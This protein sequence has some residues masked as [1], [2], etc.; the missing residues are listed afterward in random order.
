VSATPLDK[1]CT[2]ISFPVTD[3]ELQILHG[4]GEIVVHQ[5]VTAI[6]SPLSVALR[7]ASLWP[8]EL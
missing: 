6:Y 5:N 7:A 3:G 2:Q 1:D 8:A 4:G